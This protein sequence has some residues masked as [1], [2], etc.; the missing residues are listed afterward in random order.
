MR[1]HASWIARSVQRIQYV[2]SCKPR[3]SR[4]CTWPRC[5]QSWTG[6]HEE[7]GKRGSRG[8]QDNMLYMNLYFTSIHDASMHGLQNLNSSCGKILVFL[9]PYEFTHETRVTSCGVTNRSVT[10]ASRLIQ[11]LRKYVLSLWL[12]T[13][14]DGWPCCWAIQRS[15]ASSHLSGLLA[16]R[17]SISLGIL[18]LRA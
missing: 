7:S 4:R 3:T 14:L 12:N 10:G 6:I 1:W 18:S 2:S 5:S 9:D 11:Q 13:I 8:S 17:I 15:P 16:R